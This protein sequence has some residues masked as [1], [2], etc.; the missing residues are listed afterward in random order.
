MTV[1]TSR[2]NSSVHSIAQLEMIPERDDTG[3]LFKIYL[4]KLISEGM[5]MIPNAVGIIHPLDRL[6]LEFDQLYSVKVKTPSALASNAAA[7]P[8]G[9]VDSGSGTAPASASEEPPD[10]NLLNLSATVLPIGNRGEF[11]S[12]LFSTRCLLHPNAIPHNTVVSPEPNVI[13]AADSAADIQANS[14]AHRLPHVALG[15]DSNAP[16]MI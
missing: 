14:P 13:A 8:D 6:G 15:P 4:E 2:L 7:A 16:P 11:L 10:A 1:A 3:G 9:D 12:W 5:H